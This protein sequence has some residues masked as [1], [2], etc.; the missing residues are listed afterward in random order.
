MKKN[1]KKILAKFGYKI[2]RINNQA[3]IETKNES[4]DEILN[5]FLKT[6]KPFFPNLQINYKHI[7]TIY[8]C[9]YI[10]ENSIEGDLVECGVFRGFNIG[11][12]ISSIKILGSNKDQNRKIYLYDTFQ[13]M[14]KPSQF[15]QKKTLNYEQNLLKHISNQEGE[16]NKR[17]FYPL[18]KVREY[19]DSFCYKNLIYIKGDVLETLPNNYHNDAKISLMRLDT[20]FYFS[21]KHELENLYKHLSIN[22]IAIVDDYNSW[23]GQKKACDEFFEKNKFTPFYVYTP[24]SDFAWL[25]TN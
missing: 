15:D 17:C 1:L 10:L 4:V 18:D 14:T 23:S 9:K 3:D 7:N 5:Y 12:M 11:L 6:S 2:S 21:T 25:K 20:D 19:L 8:A 24:S 13:G 16:I 22:G